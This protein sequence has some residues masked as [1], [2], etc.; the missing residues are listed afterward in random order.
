LKIKI[1]PQCSKAITRIMFIMVAL[2]SGIISFI[3]SGPAVSESQELKGMNQPAVMALAMKESLEIT[4]KEISPLRRQVYLEYQRKMKNGQVLL[5]RLSQYQH[6]I[7]AAA[8]YYNLDADLVTGLIAYESGG[9]NSAVSDAQARGLMQI[10]VV[11]RGCVL[12]IKKL[13]QV[14]RLDYHNPAHNIFVG[15]ATLAQYMKNAPDPLLGLVAYNAGPSA[16]KGKSYFEFSQRRISKDIKRFPFIVSA[17]AL[18]AKV[19]KK[20]GQILPLNQEN[21]AWFDG[22]E[23]LGVN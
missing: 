2:F 19:Q 1:T 7:E 11:P 18:M 17:Y 12:K 6:I 10:Y 21:Q 16:V 8:S 15:T 23:L 14:K 13:F 4:K 9:R 5:D 20:T 3:L 22:I